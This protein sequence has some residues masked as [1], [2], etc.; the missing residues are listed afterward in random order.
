M[1]VGAED[2]R[3]SA[4]TI[5][6]VIERNAASGPAMNWI[7]RLGIALV[8]PIARALFHLRILDV[9]R[10][11]RSGA[12]ILAAN[13]VSVLD[14]PMLCLPPGHERRRII[15]FLVAAE[16]FDSRVFGPILRTAMQ[17]PIRRGKGDAHALD[18]AIAAVGEGS[19]AGV[20][21]EGQ[22]NR[23][24]PGELQRA[25]TGAARIALAAGVPV[26]P[27]GIWGTH[28]RWPR[29]G[30][31]LGRPWRVPLTIAIGSPVA[32]GGKADD[33]D[34]VKRFTDLLAGAIVEQRNRAR[35]D[36]ESRSG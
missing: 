35:A 3:P 28:L 4:G 5:R 12:A 6:R 9:E 26:I 33:P 11:P 15:R 27:V 25:R 34:A 36:A 8:W 29:A 32:A 7:W 14:G 31:R 22:V 21:P 17:I 23:G 19:L 2:S 30:I 16:V 10:I 1:C 13:H 24:D 20:F 18:A